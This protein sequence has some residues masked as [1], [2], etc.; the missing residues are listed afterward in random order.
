MA[1]NSSASSMG[2][3]GTFMANAMMMWEREHSAFDYEQVG[4]GHA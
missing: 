2:T 3:L 4:I 1:E